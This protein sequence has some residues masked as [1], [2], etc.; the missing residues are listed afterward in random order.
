MTRLFECH[1][2]KIMALSES[3]LGTLDKSHLTLSSP[4][5]KTQP[6]N[7]ESRLETFRISSSYSTKQVVDVDVVNRNECVNNLSP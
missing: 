6:P 4:R 5:V 3:T 1:S 2:L 7:L